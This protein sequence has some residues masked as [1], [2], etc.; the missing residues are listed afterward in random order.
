MV[1]YWRQR[2]AMGVELQC[3][4]ESTDCH[5]GRQGNMPNVQR[6]RTAS[7]RAMLKHLE[8]LDQ[9]PPPASEADE[10]EGEAE[11]EDPAA[12]PEDLTPVLEPPAV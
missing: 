11:D 8:L 1:E 10:D 9:L 7:Q 4:K 2:Q 6:Y 12:Q 3:S 5:F